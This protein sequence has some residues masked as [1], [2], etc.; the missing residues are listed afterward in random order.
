M[1]K[2]VDSAALAWHYMDMKNSK[3]STKSDL[4][5]TNG[6]RSW[7]PRVYVDRHPF[8]DEHNRSCPQCAR[9]IRWTQAYM[10]HVNGR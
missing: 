6:D 7:E 1:D 9:S 8:T 5:W 3:R 10:K 2:W 4:S